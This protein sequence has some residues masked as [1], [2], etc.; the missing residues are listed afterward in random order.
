MKKLRKYIHKGSNFILPNLFILFYETK[1]R[2]NLD[3]Q[4]YENPKNSS[5]SAFALWLRLT[6]HNFG[7]M[8][9]YSTSTHLRIDIWEIK[10]T[11]LVDFTTTGKSAMKGTANT[12][13]NIRDFCTTTTTTKWD[14]HRD[15]N[16][17]R[18][19][20]TTVT[21]PSVVF[22]PVCILFLGLVFTDVSGRR[23]H[24][25]ELYTL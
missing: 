20:C 1:Q 16:W 6:S 3:L 14:V 25:Q 21:A 13:Q 9:I 24:T 22:I 2:F 10:E 5:S 12:M 17:Q 23:K 15:H 18:S 11:A 19:Q 8:L 7:Q 4:V